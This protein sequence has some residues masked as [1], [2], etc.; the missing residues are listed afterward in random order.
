[1][2]DPAGGAGAQ[3]DQDDRESLQQRIDELMR[4]P[5][6]EPPSI[7]VVGDENVFGITPLGG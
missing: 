6:R 7:I 2:A 4:E 5:P 3:P 1:M